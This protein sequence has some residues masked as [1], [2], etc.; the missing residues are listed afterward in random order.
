MTPGELFKKIAEKIRNLFAVIIS[1]LKRVISS[2]EI[3]SLITF[4]K[5]AGTAIINTLGWLVKKTI[6]LISFLYE[7][8]KQS[9]I[10]P[11][12]IRFLESLYSFL[13]EQV[14]PELQSYLKAFY[15]FLKDK[16]LP[17]IKSFLA[18]VYNILRNFFDRFG[19]FALRRPGIFVPAL[20]FVYLIILTSIIYYLMFSKYYWA[21]EPDKKFIIKSGKNLTEIAIELEEQDIISSA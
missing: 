6:K 20:V 8:I 4:L 14:L 13:K 17:G 11:K 12:I 5:S 16:L 10:I 2:D 3:K 7:K 21:G 1:F 15:R 9:E 18:Q 19:N